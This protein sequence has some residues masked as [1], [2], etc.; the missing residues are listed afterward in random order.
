M[1]FTFTALLCLGLTLGLWIPVLTGAYGKPSLSAQTSHV[2]T[3]GDYVTL[4]CESRQYYHGFI[5]MVE[6]PQKLF[7]K[8]DSQYNLST[9]KF[10]ALF[11]VGPVS[12]NQRWIYKCYSYD[13]NKPQVWSEPSEPL[14]L[15]VSGNLQKPT[16]KA[17]PGS[18]ITSRG[19]MTIWCQG[20]LDAEIC[21]LNKEVISETWS[22]QTSQEPGNKVKFFIPSVTEEHT[23]HYRCYCYS[24]AGWSEPSDTLELVVT[25][26]GTVRFSTPGSALRSIPL[27]QSVP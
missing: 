9:G 7:W 12:P 24:S 3:S 22:T 27:P 11:S 23:G 10:Q 14:E 13:K 18:V 4:L 26:E 21:F 1:T 2:V 20:N 19:A 6:G 16:I 17:E 5:L 8:Q 15:L 25:G